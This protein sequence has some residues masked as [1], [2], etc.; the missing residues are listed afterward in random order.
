ML[1]PQ[2]FHGY[3]LAF[4]IAICQYMYMVCI[5]CSKKTKTTISRSSTNTP[6][7]WRRHKCPS[8]KAV[9][10][11][12]ELPD[13]GMSISVSQNNGQI[14]AFSTD[15][16]FVSVYRSLSHRRSPIEDSRGITTTITE[17]ACQLQRNGV[18]SKEELQKTISEVLQRFDKV[19]QVHY[20]AHH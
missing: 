3:P 18:L 19:A 15:K 16:V 2:F 11:S 9:F 10:T 8:C 17:S 1:K 7:T 13:W 6:K 4:Y 12:R 5:Y 14:R 20:D